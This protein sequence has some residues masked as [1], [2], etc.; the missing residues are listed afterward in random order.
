M[1]AQQEYKLQNI[2][3]HSDMTSP[4]ANQHSA[5]ITM[6]TQSTKT[7][8]KDEYTNGCETTWIQ[9]ANKQTIPTQTAIQGTRQEE[10]GQ[11]PNQNKTLITNKHLTLITI[12]NTVF[13]LLLLYFC[14]KINSS[15]FK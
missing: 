2:T 12:H 8:T 3:T 7:M 10:S 15:M 9:N 6:P 1:R 14:F 4:T 5:Y 13:L 11:L